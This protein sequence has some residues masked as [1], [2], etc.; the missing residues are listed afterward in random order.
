MLNGFR[1]LRR[2]AT[3]AV[4]SSPGPAEPRR[5]HSAS[6]GL[7]E[8]AFI[9]GTGAFG[10]YEI[11]KGMF[12]MPQHE[13]TVEE[14]TGRVERQ[15]NRLNESQWSK[16]ILEKGADEVPAIKVKTTTVTPS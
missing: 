12:M 6:R 14:I 7:W 3:N 10:L 5:F 13:P 8:M 9:G 4:H 2:M 1:N 15:R 11:Y 16:V